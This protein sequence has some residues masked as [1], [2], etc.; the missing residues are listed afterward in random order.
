[1]ASFCPGDPFTEILLWPGCVGFCIVADTGL[2]A[3]LPLPAVRTPE[4]AALI[5]AGMSHDP[6]GRS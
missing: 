6:T 4:A 5:V 1:M 3:A 2:V